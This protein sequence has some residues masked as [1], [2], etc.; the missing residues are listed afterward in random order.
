MFFLNFLFLLLSQSSFASAPVQEIELNADFRKVDE[1]LTTEKAGDLSF[2]VPNPHLQFWAVKRDVS[3]VGLSAF[4]RSDGRYGVSAKTILSNSKGYLRGGG[5]WFHSLADFWCEREPNLWFATE[6]GSQQALGRAG[7][8][9]SELLAT[10]KSRLSVLMGQVSES[11]EKIALEKGTEIFSRWLRGVENDWRTQVIPQVRREEWQS[12][13]K[14]VGQKECSSRRA[15]GKLIPDYRAMLEPLEGTSPR[16]TQLLARAPARSWNGLFSVRLS[17]QV[18]GKK[19]NGQFLIDSGAPV[20][21]I[22]PHWLESQ[23]VYPSWVVLPAR[24]PEKVIWSHPT[25][26]QE[27]LALRAFLKKVELSGLEIPL[28]EFLLY[29]TDFFSTPENLSSCCDGVLGSDFLSLFP[30]EFKVTAPLEVRVWPKKGFQGLADTPWV[31]VNQERQGSLVSACKLIPQ[32]EKT[33]LK[34]ARYSGVSWSTGSEDALETF[35]SSSKLPKGKAPRFWEIECNGNLFAQ[36]QTAFV[37]ESKVDHRPYAARVGMPLL[38]RGSFTFDLPHG[39]LWFEKEA[40]GLKQNWENHSGLSL[41]FILHDGDRSLVVKSIQPRSSAEKLLK[42]GLKPS[43]EIVEM[44]GLPSGELD[45]WEVE[46][47]L[48]GKYRKSV[49]L[50]WKTKKGFKMAP[51]EL[52]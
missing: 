7:M 12:Y 39:R 29:E 28:H 51:I 48:A 38:S 45:F 11:S 18:N 37:S 23:G 44:D 25:E 17:V 46:Q 15:K 9:W 6:E 5:P 35:I 40:L 16:V 21:V 14:E 27:G 50:K 52:K 41:E 24:T 26:G 33:D 4:L 30:V 49:T 34:Q 19:L 1:K 20:S 2:G 8:K 43:V 22:S 3:L 31:E 42:L 47:R 32:T 36:D 10:E 13:L